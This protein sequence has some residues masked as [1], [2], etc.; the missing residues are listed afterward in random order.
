MIKRDE[1]SL[2]RA[3][4]LLG[5]NQIPDEKLIRVLEQIK[6]FCKVAY[7]L[8]SQKSKKENKSNGGEGLGIDPGH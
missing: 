8:Y 5:E 7:L 3:K 4:S 2:Q 6:A 1:L